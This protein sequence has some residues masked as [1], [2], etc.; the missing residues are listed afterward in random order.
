[1]SVHVARELEWL[2]AIDET[3]R[4]IIPLAPEAAVSLR[5]RRVSRHFLGI[6][7]TIVGDVG[8]AYCRHDGRGVGPRADDS[9]GY[10]IEPN[11]SGSAHDRRI[12]GRS[13]PR[14]CG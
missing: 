8:M 3:E 14:G 7:C 4:E 10:V 2:V 12:F 13:P 5:R 9:M 1:M 6:A 11:L